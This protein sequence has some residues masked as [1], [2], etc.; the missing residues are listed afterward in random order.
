MHSMIPPNTQLPPSARVV[1]LLLGDQLNAAHSWWE[2]CDP[3]VL[4]VMMECRQ[5]TDYARH[6]VQK[7]LAFFLA[8]RSFATKRIATGHRM[9]YLPIDGTEAARPMM[10]ILRDIVTGC[11]ASEVRFQLPDEWRLDQLIQDAATS[12]PV[13]LGVDVHVDDTEHF[14]TSRTD[15]ADHFQ[16]KKQFLMES[17]YRMMRRRH[18]VL[19]DAAGEPEGGKWNFDANNRKKLPKGHVPPAPRLWDRDVTELLDSIHGAGVERCELLDLFVEE[20]LPRFGDFQDALTEDSWTVYHSRLS[21]AMNTKILSPREVIEAVE[22]KW[23][24]APEHASIE[25]VEGFIRQ[26]LGWREYMRGIYWA[27]M[28]EYATLNFFQHD[29][30]LPGW[31]WTGKTGMR[32]LQHA[33]TQT[34]D[35]AY[36]HHIQRLMVTGN[37]ALLAGIDPDEVDAWYLGVYIDALEWVEITNTR[38]MSQFADGGIVGSKPY[39]SS[40]NYMHKMGPHCAAC[41]YNRQGK[42]EDDACPFNSLYW[43]FHARNRD[44]LERNPRIGM[45][46]RTW[47][48]MH[49]P[50]QQALLDRGDAVLANLEFL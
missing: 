13:E 29:R 45:V 18:D 43:H 20:L 16:G 36:A 28:P 50:Q 22:R 44:L 15:L 21:F 30:K 39:V 23:R 10:D 26:I 40:A 4:T 27:K 25:Q 38:G 8:M 49:A 9:H 34:L 48:K 33:I 3:D 41:S 7:V 17:F 46:Y 32:C 6:H 37:F 24:E 12:W 42:T 2:T 31:F 47:D 1:R 35:Y 14:L 11:G 5:E 19:M